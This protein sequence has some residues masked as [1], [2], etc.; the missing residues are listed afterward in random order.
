MRIHTALAL[1]AAG[2]AA[3]MFFAP[4]AQADVNIGNVDVTVT[5]VA[6]GNTFFVLQNVSVDQA[7]QVCQVN[8]DVVTATLLRGDSAK[9]NSKTN[10]HQKAWIKK[11]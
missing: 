10:N 8:V 4:L 7:A 1:A 5:E 2:T 3:A 11:H 9:C 6:S